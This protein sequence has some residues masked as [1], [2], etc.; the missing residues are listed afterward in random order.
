MADQPQRAILQRNCE[1]CGRPLPLRGDG[2]AVFLVT[3]FPEQALNCYVHLQVGP[4]ALP[5]S[6]CHHINHLG[7]P[8]AI[9]DSDGQ[10]LLY[11]PDTVA[12]GSSA[13]QTAIKVFRR[14]LGKEPAVV[15]DSRAFRRTFIEM[16]LGRH[17]NLLNDF[18]GTDDNL[19]VWITNH[20]KE[21]DHAFFAAGWLAST[22]ALQMLARPIEAGAPRGV[23][24]HEQASEAERHVAQQRAVQQQVAANLGHLIAGLLAVWVVRIMEA[25][26]FA[27]FLEAAPRLLPKIVL[28]GDVAPPL[29]ERIGEFSGKFKLGEKGAILGRYV[30]DAVL[31]VLF[32]A[33]DLANPRRKEWT[34]ILVLYEYARRLDG[35]DESLLLD[36]ELLSRSIDREEFLRSVRAI[37]ADLGSLDQETTERHLHLLETVGRILPDEVE[38][39]FQPELAVGGELPASEAVKQT[40][41]MFEEVLAKFPKENSD[42]LVAAL[43]RGLQRRHPKIVVEAIRAMWAHAVQHLTP[44][45]RIEFARRAIE[46]LNLGHHFRQA[47]DLAT[48]AEA[49]MAGVPDLS[50][51]QRSTFLNEVGNCL[52][53]AGEFD[54]ALQ[55]YEAAEAA[56]G[57]DGGRNKRVVIRNR[58]IVLRSQ[59]RYFEA[60]KIFAQLRAETH[61]L[62][63]LQ[64]VVSESVTLMDMG[65]RDAAFML[66]EE[67]AGL[68]SGH[69][70]GAPPAREYAALRAQLLS[71][72]GRHREAA[73]LATLLLEASVRFADPLYAAV[74]ARLTFDP[75]A[76]DVTKA[77]R[78]R[79]VNDALALVQEGLDRAREAE[80]MPDA[81]LG[82][83]E[84][85]NLMLNSLGRDAE[86][87]KLVREATEQFDPEIA[88][89]GWLLCLYAMQ[90]AVRRRDYPTAIGDMVTALTWIELGLARTAAT[91]DAIAFLAPHSK[92]VEEL[93]EAV[94]RF[95]IEDNP[96]L[97]RVARIAADLTAA[98]VLTARVRG[99]LGL[100]SPS[101]V[102]P[103]EELATIA[104]FCRETPA[105]FVQTVKLAGDIGLLVTVARQGG[106]VESTL[107]R[108][109]LDF[110]LDEIQATLR[111]LDFRLRSASP[112][113]PSLALENV[114]GWPQLTR[115]LC[116]AISDLPSVAPLCV[117]PGPLSSQAFSLTFGAERPLCF[118]PSLGLLLALRERRRRLPAGLGWRPRDMFDFAVWRLGDKPTVV[119]ALQMAVSEGAVVARDQGLAHEARSG[120]QGDSAAL[121]SGLMRADFTRVACHG[122]ILPNEDALDLVVAADGLLPPASA[123][124]LAGHE[125]TGHIL[126]WQR[127][128]ELANASPVVFSSACDSG[129]AIL[130]VGGERLGLERPLFAAGTITY[131][132]PQWPVPVVAIQQFFSMMLGEYLKDPTRSVADILR[133]TRVKATAAGL[134]PLAVSAPA[135]FGDGL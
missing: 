34:R 57:G 49:L 85:L 6:N 79:R 119:Q 62:E 54:A 64:N 117:V 61:D 29:A 100:S 15:R 16:F 60:R 86:A 89:R 36:P 56:L 31:A 130:H 23:L 28:I 35:N 18:I 14:N 58:A 102:E 1:K 48:E 99:S 75:T 123:A 21:L 25:R 80:G 47:R 120:T 93:A 53:Y 5:C 91:A 52:R 87:E 45:R 84:E 98:P 81:L 38:Q 104:T 125:A 51:F 88:P 17:I 13:E 108:L 95:K 122:R 10:G 46:V 9:V 43:M 20:Q 32:A 40:V 50:S 121:L 37:G 90:H 59:Q 103:D 67:H 12:Q 107:R 135:V 112:T 82:L 101:L 134:S 131:V 63:L 92:K 11:M 3:I 94:H 19:H 115:A 76:P 128:S 109:S 30:Y 113:A 116:E 132:A 39:V 8:Q 106:G 7:L 77:E 41:A 105:V 129:A 2:D 96:E 42:M 55:R 72:K 97:Q 73:E 127:L 65:E 111:R 22:G 133:D 26:S 4:G 44:V 118:A 27:A 70:M 71:W 114:R 110:D 68:A 66:V 124:G 83:T 126:G 33:H 24:P 78:N 74:A 69:G